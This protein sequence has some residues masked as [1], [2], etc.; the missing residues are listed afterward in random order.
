MLW[1]TRTGVLDLDTR[2]IVIGILNV[3][4]DSFSDG[5]KYLD[6]AFALA[7]A[8]QMLDEG[9][10]IID[11]GGEST[12]P[13]ATPVAEEVERERVI[14][15]IEAL[16]KRR[17]ALISIDTSK[18]PVARAAVEVGAAIINDVTG[19]S[20]D[21]EMIEVVRESGVGLIIMHMRGTPQTM[22]ISPEYG[23]VVA[24]I[25]N[26]FRQSH[27]RIL[28]CGIDPTRIAFD[29][30][31]GFGKTVAHNLQILQ[32]VTNLRVENRPLAI[33]VSRKSFLGKVMGDQTIERRDAA[34]ANL[35]ALLRA[36]GVNIFRVHNVRATRDAIQVSD[37]VL[38]A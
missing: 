24:E 25:R 27:A 2:A 6:P 34:S 28:N 18:A 8:E 19:L 11:I 14:P 20:G 35:A 5:G 26:F 38:A 17:S 10:D 1:R 4:V 37:A 15:I 23:D 31:I 22:Q 13:G 21:L 32:G 33:G 36:K 30:G 16:A 7:H 3:T 29:P 12:R 9:A